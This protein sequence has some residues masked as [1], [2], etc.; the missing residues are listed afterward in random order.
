MTADEYD[1]EEKKARESIP[2]FPFSDHSII[3]GRYAGFSLKA[4]HPAHSGRSVP[5]S[6]SS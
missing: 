4:L 3:A 6:V 5:G 1:N 2:G